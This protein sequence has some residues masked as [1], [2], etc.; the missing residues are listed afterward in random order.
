MNDSVNVGIDVSKDRL[1]IAILPAGEI[2]HVPNDEAGHAL[3]TARLE[4]EGSLFRIVLEATGGYERQAALAL[5][6]AGLPVVIVNPRQ[7]RDYAR[8]TGRIAK[9]DRLDAITLAEFASAVK[10][11]LRDLGAPA[12]HA[13]ASLVARRRQLVT[14]IGSERQRRKAASTDVVRTDIEATLAF[15]QER[16]A[17]IEKTLLAAIEFDPLWRHRMALLRSVPGVGTITSVTLLADFPELGTLTGK[18]TAA[19]AGLAPMN[20]DSGKKRGKRRTI[21]GRGRVRKVLYMATLTAVR[22][23]PVLQTFYERL[24]DAGKPAKVALT[25]CMRKLLL[26]LNTMLKNEQAW[27]PPNAE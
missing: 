3:L 23:N 12:Q 17:A 9:T 24:I 18:E 13:L 2:L 5:F 6:A 26:I 21:G 7:T 20:R 4:A 8:A 22:H 19:L 15:L 16:L 11:V 1:D 10:P 27:A 25:A 14:M